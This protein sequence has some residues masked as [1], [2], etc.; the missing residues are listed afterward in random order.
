M[1]TLGCLDILY[2]VCLAPLLLLSADDEVGRDH[3]VHLAGFHCSS[4]FD[5]LFLFLVPASIDRSR[6][7]YYPS[8]IANQSKTLECP[9]VGIPPPRLTWVKDGQVMSVAGRPDVRLLLEGRRLEILSTQV[10]DAGSYE[11]RAENEAGRDQIS[12]TLKVFGSFS[13]FC[14]LLF[15]LLFCFQF[16]QL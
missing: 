4:E 9:A 5:M 11:C 16:V 6:L 13:I 15:I 7:D 10:K 3:D 8:V 2:R 12:Y 1:Q 14:L